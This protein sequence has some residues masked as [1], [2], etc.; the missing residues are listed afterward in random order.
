MNPDLDRLA[1]L[2]GIEST[3]VGIDGKRRDVRDEAKRAIL[4]AMGVWTE[5][6]QDIAEAARCAMPIDFGAMEAPAGIRCFVPPWLKDGRT[7]GVTCQVYA[8]RS[9]RN[10]GIGDFEDLARLAE[11]A[12]AEGADFV[13]VNPLHALFLA[14]AR[15]FSPFSPSNRQFL[16]PLYI[17]VDG[18]PGAAALDLDAAELD[19][20][21]ASDRVLYPLVALAKKRALEALF[22]AFGDDEANVS[23][24]QAFCAEHGQPLYLHALFEAISERMVADGRWSGWHGWPAEFQDHGSLAVR[25]FAEEHEDRVTFHAWLQFIA[26]RQ[27]AEAQ[28]RAIAAGMRIGLYVDLAVGVASDGSATWSDPAL[29]VPDARI[30]APPDFFNAAGQD[31]GIAPLSPATL[32][33]RRFEP[34]RTALDDVLRRAGAVRI[35][36]A[37]SLYRLYWIAS[38]FSAADGVY[39]RYPFQDMLQSL[40]EISQA[41]HAIVIGEDL[42]VVPEGFRDV[43]AAMDIH[44]YRVFF[45][46][47]RDD[48]FLPPDAYPHASMACISIHDLPPL[49]GWWAGHDLETRAA[50]GMNAPEDLPAQQES[51]AHERRRMLGALADAGLLP[52]EAE[53]MMRGDVDAPCALPPEVAVALHRFMA[54]TP[55]RLFAIPLDDLVGAIEQVNIPGTTDEHPNWQMKLEVPVERLVET[56]LYRAICRAVREERPK[57]A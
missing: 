39:V 4:R 53:A 21:R 56:A 48:F 24:F 30:G 19:E 34:Y 57:Q 31:W 43:M 10:W 16:N 55:S 44:S 14:D 9:G 41:R 7:W 54:R 18:V 25:N 29:T 6:E 27:L 38:G 50:I 33:Q 1:G 2:Y 46:E 12:A 37:M 32:V 3:Y 36:H 49:A 42:G 15:R 40:A 20:L 22:E 23:A 47:R 17:A 5:T 45:F 51:R 52:A 26:D 8:L 28:R 35:D 13:G 11:I